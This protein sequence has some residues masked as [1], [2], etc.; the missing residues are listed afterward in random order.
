MRVYY[1]V[2][3]ERSLALSYFSRATEMHLLVAEILAFGHRVMK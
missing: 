2:T 3:M 1:N